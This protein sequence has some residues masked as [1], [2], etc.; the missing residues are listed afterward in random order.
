MILSKQL[1][2][3]IRKFTNKWKQ[4]RKRWMAMSEIWRGYWK[5]TATFDRNNLNNQSTRQN[6]NMLLSNILFFSPWNS[7]TKN[8]M[9][10][11]HSIFYLPPWVQHFKLVP[12]GQLQNRIS[13]IGVLKLFCDKTHRFQRHYKICA[14]LN[15]SGGEGAVEK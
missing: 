11:V 2:T 14:T 13:Y 7:Q 10:R 9:K 6:V 1:K 8:P 4:R 3:H 12:S 15:Y 5:S